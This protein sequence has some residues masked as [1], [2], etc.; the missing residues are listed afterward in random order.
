MRNQRTTKEVV[1][2]TFFW[3]VLLTMGLFALIGGTDDGRHAA[4]QA[5]DVPPM[6]AQAQERS[7]QI[8]EYQ[9]ILQTDPQNLDA[10]IALGDL[11]FEAHQY[12]EAMSVFLQ[13]EKVAPDNVH[14]NNDLG[15]LALNMR[16]YDVAIARFKRALQAN[17]S[18]VDSLYYLGVAYRH[19]GDLE[20]AKKTFEQVL[21]ANPA[22]R[23]AQKATEELAALEQ[24]A[25]A[26]KGQP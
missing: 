19:K 20:T 8:A 15:L 22:P 11:Y 9:R 3:S 23:L 13:A 16:R 7:A 6:Q 4:D 21:A 25:A 17:P 12:K 24:A 14:V 1:A 26:G 18:G 10:L 2:I 5:A